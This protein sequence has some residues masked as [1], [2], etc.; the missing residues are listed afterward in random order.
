MRA[1]LATQFSIVPHGGRYY[2][3]SAFAAI[4][5][6]YGAA[7]G[8]LTL[9]V[10]VKQTW[11]PLLEDVTEA[12]SQ[13]VPVSRNS[14]LRRQ[15]REMTRAIRESDL[16]IVRCHSFV[17]FWASDLAHRLKKPV[18]AE[19]MSCPWDAMWNHGPLGKLI[20][21]YMFL[22]MRRVMARADYALYVTQE[23]LQRRYP[24]RNPW[25][26]ASNVA[27][28]AP[29][30]EVLTRRLA[31]IAAQDPSRVTLMTCAA[32]NV[33]HKGHR[34]VIRAIPQLNAMGIRVRYFCVGQGDPHVLQSLAARCGVSDQVVFTGALPHEEIFS[35]L[36]TCDI[37]VQPSLQEGLPRALIEAMSRGCPCI[38][39]RTA[40]IPELLPEE[41]LT[42]RGSA[43]A[44]A[45]A[46]SA[47]LRSDLSRYACES[48]RTALA[49]QGPVLDAR[50]NAF[51]DRIRREVASASGGECS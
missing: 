19:A 33:A 31:H 9:C 35:M 26:G 13:M 21:P 44:I 16:V 46:V 42:P 28:P 20:A 11:S 17:A 14:I 39:A 29:S 38:G 25:I 41:C 47:M 49:Y 22:K 30:E 7:F 3:K 48:C 8:P 40:G 6:R 10:P 34:F 1:L 43:G 37:Y 12:V 4:L 27:L 2:T 15:R 45:G 51:F 23:F 18:L 50:R 32:V 36:D 24:C 5:R